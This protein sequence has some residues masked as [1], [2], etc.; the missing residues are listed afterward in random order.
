MN[1]LPRWHKPDW[2]AYIAL[3]LVVFVRFIG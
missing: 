3:K 2:L 1:A